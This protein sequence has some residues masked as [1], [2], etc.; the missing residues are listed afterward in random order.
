MFTCN[1]AHNN[2]EVR[3]A[4]LPERAPRNTPLDT[5]IQPPPAI[6]QTLLET[7][8]TE[9][10]GIRNELV[11]NQHQLLEKIV[12]VGADVKQ[13]Q[14]KL[15]SD[16]YCA[17]P[18]AGFSSPRPSGSTKSFI[19]KPAITLDNS[20]KIMA[21]Q[22]QFEQ[23]KGE[24]DLVHADAGLFGGRSTV[25]L[26]LHLI[27]CLILGACG[28]WCYWLRDSF[29]MPWG[30]STQF[31][32]GVY[33]LSSATAGVAI[34]VR[35]YYLL[36]H[37]RRV[38]LPTAVALISL[39]MFFLVGET[40][41]FS[42][43]SGANLL[44]GPQAAALPPWAQVIFVL[45]S[46]WVGPVTCARMALR[47]FLRDPSAKDFQTQWLASLSLWELGLT[48]TISPAYPLF[49]IFFFSTAALY[50]I[51][52]FF[53]HRQVSSV[54]HKADEIVRADKQTYD[55]RW[56]AIVAEPDNA[57][58]L[59][60][61]QGVVE[62]LPAVIPTNDEAN[63]DH[64]EDKGA[65]KGGEKEEVEQ[66][67]EEAEEE[68]EVEE[69]GADKRIVRLRAE[70]LRALRQHADGRISPWGGGGR[71]KR[72]K[73]KPRQLHADLPYLYAQAHALN[74]HFQARMVQW[75]GRSSEGTTVHHCDPDPDPN[76]TV[77]HCDV[78]QR[79]RAIDKTWR[80]YAGDPSLLLDLVRGSITCRTV[81]GI[82]DC[83]ARIQA[84]PGV[85][86]LNVKNRFDPRYDGHATAG[87]RNLALLLVIV[88][89]ETARFGVHDHV[90]ELQLGLAQINEL[91]TAGGH[92]NYREWRDMR[93]V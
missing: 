53:M 57:G 65:E 11:T 66:E 82:M 26:I 40:M 77:H 74:P 45:A 24:A 10:H 46:L 18:L 3:K 1:Q 21:L 47:V 81:R 90:C 84:D 72:T 41:K 15:P 39:A 35:L 50:L 83:L 93:A 12:R 6:M 56:A 58:Q 19:G 64:T 30:L 44:F 33:W 71:A 59:S 91:K 79:R 28:I 75:A 22:R 20:L 16:N 89:A 88:D 52:A 73:S 34:A 7:L 8:R 4:S 49:R 70:T 60:L 13:M 62:K 32:I 31:V 2:E 43:M 67:R 78:K 17:N 80:C 27:M 48:L 42:N 9:M 85:F 76:I 51:G 68:E 37:P 5:S 14:A 87:Y 63:D 29:H 36:Y 92:R 55:T 69:E 25:M 61:L 86:V 54:A 38:H 23:A